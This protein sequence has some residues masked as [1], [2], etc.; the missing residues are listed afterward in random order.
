MWALDQIREEKQIIENVLR[1]A[2]HTAMLR[3]ISSLS[4][5][6][7][8]IEIVS[9]IQRGTTQSS[10]SCIFLNV[11]SEDDVCL[12]LQRLNQQL[13][14]QQIAAPRTSIEARLPVSVPFTTG[15]TELV[16]SLRCANAQKK[17]ADL[18]LSLHSRSVLSSL[19]PH[20]KTSQVDRNF[21]VSNIAS[22]P[23]AMRM[24][25]DP[26]NSGLLVPF[27]NGV[28]GSLAID[29]TVSASFAPNRKKSAQSKRN[30]EPRA[31]TGKK[32]RNKQTQDSKWYAMLASLENFKKEY[33]H[34]IVPRGFEDTRLAIWVSVQQ[35]ICNVH[36]CYLAANQ[37]SKII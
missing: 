37:N 14:N 8:G 22:D 24:P 10:D 12:S 21:Q 32:D 16:A 27:R 7:N 33:G 18:L 31:Y 17:A 1:R 36:L 30:A 13:D 26:Q 5:P 28:D 9:Q 4:R 15:I 25:H 6:L 2:N 35:Y 20:N 19:E 29:K 3:S 34:C 23:K 11:N